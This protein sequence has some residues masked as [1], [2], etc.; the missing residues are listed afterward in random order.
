MN[1]ELEFNCGTIV[2]NVGVQVMAMRHHLRV[3]EDKSCIADVESN[4][5][6]VYIRPSTKRGEQHGK[7]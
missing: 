7:A 3:C 4:I 2:S 1:V 6:K 5:L